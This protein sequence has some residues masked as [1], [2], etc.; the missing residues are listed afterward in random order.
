M[1][2]DDSDKGGGLCWTLIIN[3]R[4]DEQFSGK[5]FVYSVDFKFAQAD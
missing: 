2:I 1:A 4:N 3:E 5:F